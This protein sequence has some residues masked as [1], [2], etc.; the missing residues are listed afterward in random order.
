MTSEGKTLQLPIPSRAPLLLLALSLALWCSG[1]PAAA[2]ETEIEGSCTACHRDPALLVRNK[3]LYDYFQQWDGSI[4]QQEGVTCDKCHGGNRKAANKDQ[5][6][7]A[8]V[9]A[10]NPSSGVYYAKIPRTCGKCHEDIL[11]GFQKSN[12]YEHVAAEGEDRQGP[13]CVTCHGS[14]DA[15]IL[16]V[17]SVE[18]AC[19]RCHNFETDNNPDI[20]AKAREALNKFLSIHRFYRYIT[21]KAEPEDAKQFFAD[22]DPRLRRLSVTWHTFDLDAIGAG[23]EEVLDLLKAKRDELRRKR[24]EA[25]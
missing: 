22:L 14:I 4:H 2:A 17:N 11:E 24:A 23:I 5:A 9:A 10:S 25:K 7:G 16:D 8:G 19:A 12:H 15:E 18:A 1:Q 3:K 13:T 21:I 6:H 20:P